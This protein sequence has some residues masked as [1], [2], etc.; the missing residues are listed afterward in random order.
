MKKFSWIDVVAL[1]IWIIPIVYL[2]NVYAS[3]PQTVAVHFD[4]EG[5]P[6]RYGDK[7]EMLFISLLLSGISAGLY[8]LLKFLPSI[9]PKKMAKY[10]G[11]AF[12][13]MALAILILFSAISIMIVHSAIAGK[14]T[15]DKLM[16]PFIGLFIAFVG[17]IMHNI[18]PN[19]FAGI[20]TPWTL[21][22]PE[23]WKA[24]HR[25]GSKL[26]FIGGIVIT[27]MTL[28]LPQKVGYIF[29]MTVLITISLIP[30]IYS[31]TYYKKH[32]Q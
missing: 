17:N 24:T 13:K 31:Y 21:E 10:S 27:I 6:N 18:K 4:L 25:L 3:L 30:V 5:K 2:L 14:I 9:D 20:R 7:S 12:K 28:L 16:F 22:D 11:A 19:Y 1:I 26:W 15:L 32:K 23:T 29:F 8:F